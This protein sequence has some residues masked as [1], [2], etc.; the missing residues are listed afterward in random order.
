MKVWVVLKGSDLYEK[1][2]MQL[3]LVK[4]CLANY[5]YKI[6]SYEFTGI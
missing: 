3:N 1:T 4:A 2:F 5:V 6:L